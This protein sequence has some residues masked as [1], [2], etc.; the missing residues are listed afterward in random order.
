MTK[1]FHQTPYLPLKDAAASLESWNGFKTPVKGLATFD[2]LVN[3][4]KYTQTFCIAGSEKSMPILCRD[5]CVRLNLVKRVS[6]VDKKQDKKL[7]LI[8]KNEDLFVGLGK[9][10]EP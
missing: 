8:L 5:T 4:K 3:G 9:F 2:I 7:D 6:S 1:L 10:S